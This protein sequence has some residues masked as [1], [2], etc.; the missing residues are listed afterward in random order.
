M[1]KLILVSLLSLLP[2]AAEETKKTTPAERLLEIT[3]FEQTMMET[4]DA[5]FQTVKDS[6]AVHNLNAEEMSEVKDAFMA[7]MG[8]LAADPE[9]RKR[10][11]ELYNEN[12]TEEEINELIEFYETPLGQKTLTALPAIMGE[13]LQLSMKLAQKH[14]GIFQEALTKILA[15]KAK[16]EKGDE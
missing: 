13:T 12:F 16:A 11:I 5:S 9:L 2:L 8:K 15:R 14:V 1:K 6:L 10:T 4:G 7:Y 3:R